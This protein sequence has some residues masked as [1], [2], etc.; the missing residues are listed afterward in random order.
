GTKVYT[1]NGASSFAGYSNYLKIGDNKSPWM[2]GSSW[3]GNQTHRL[4]YIDNIRYGNEKATYADV[5]PGT[6]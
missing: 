3:G 1:K 5:A 4:F 6:K 2:P